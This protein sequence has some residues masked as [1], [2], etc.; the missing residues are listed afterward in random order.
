MEAATAS[1][2]RLDSPDIKEVLAPLHARRDQLLA[3]EEE[4]EAQKQEL[5]SERL[6]IEKHLK[7]EGLIEVEKKPQ[8]KRA[9]SSNGYPNTRRAQENVEAVEKLLDSL[10]EGEDFQIKTIEEGTGITRTGVQRI[11]DHLHE[12][13]KI[14]L[15]GYQTQIGRTKPGGRKAVTYRKV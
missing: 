8:R 5:R 13:G 7:I 10:D 12:H 14:R 15:M 2:P 1:G 11:L 6:R 3:A 9:S 4:L